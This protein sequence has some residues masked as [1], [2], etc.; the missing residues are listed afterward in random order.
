MGAR[1]HKS[2]SEWFDKLLKEITLKQQIKLDLMM[3]DY[4]NWKNGEYLGNVELINKQVNSIIETIK[5]WKEN[6]FINP[7]E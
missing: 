5:E 3:Q 1:K 7:I 2:K 6:N 4:D